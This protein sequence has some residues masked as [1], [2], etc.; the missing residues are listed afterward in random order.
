MHRSIAG[1]IVT[2]AMAILAAPLVVDAQPS[3]HVP[4]I[5][6]LDSGERGVGK[7]FR[8]GLQALGYVEGQ[9]VIL[10]WL[11]WEGHPDRAPKLIAELVQLKVDVLVVGGNRLVK[12][13]QQATAT[14]P[15]VMV[16]GGDPVEHGFVASL[17]RPGGNITGLTVQNPELGGKTLEL[18]KE[19]LPQLSRIAVLREVGG[20]PATWRSMEVAAQALRVQLQI[21]EVR[22]PDEFSRAFQTAVEGDAEAL[23]VWV[24]AMLGAHLAQIADFALKS[25]LPAIGHLRPSAEAGLLIS[26]GPDVVDL[27]RRAATYA[28]KILKGAK[29]G[30]LPVERPSKFELVINLK[31]AKAL[32]LTIPPML[33]FQAD[34]L[35]Q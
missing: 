28:D 1:L 20:D 26:Y 22:S 35:I 10:E 32:G 11:S 8:Q 12:A 34:E 14:I 5:G 23:L 7:A 21:L 18:L 17:A 4:R 33:L 16:A 6:F 29:P 31:T 30:D 19:T 9:D 27:F 2:V 15:I 13:A 25:R 3:A 24:S